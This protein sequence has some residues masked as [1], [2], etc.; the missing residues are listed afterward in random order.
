MKMVEEK[1]HTKK[2]K[3]DGKTYIKMSDRREFDYFGIF[4]AY[5]DSMQFDG[6]APVLVCK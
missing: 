2:R 4:Y 1:C 5:V 3:I 6:D